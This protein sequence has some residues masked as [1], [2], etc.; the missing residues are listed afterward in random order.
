MEVEANGM[1]VHE[2]GAKA[3]PPPRPMSAA[4]EA[5][6]CRSVRMKSERQI[7]TKRREL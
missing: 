7:T 5:E 3:E 2:G 1:N 4:D 6:R